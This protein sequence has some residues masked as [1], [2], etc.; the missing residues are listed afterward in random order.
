MLLKR[1][2]PNGLLRHWLPLL[3]G[4]PPRLAS[5]AS[6]VSQ[7]FIG[8][9]IFSGMLITTLV[10]VVF[11]PARYLHIQQLRER[12]KALREKN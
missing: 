6:A 12:G 5:G 7:P 1:R 8:V 4:F 11:I 3:T 10:G 9:T 2:M